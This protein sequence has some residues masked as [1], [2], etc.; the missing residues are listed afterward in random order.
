VVLSWLQAAATARLLAAR[1]HAWAKAHG[2]LLL[3][4]LLASFFF[5]FFFLGCYTCAVKLV[6]P[7]SSYK[8]VIPC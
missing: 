1:V 2:L 5:F 3:G 8:L 7:P 4:W 6:T